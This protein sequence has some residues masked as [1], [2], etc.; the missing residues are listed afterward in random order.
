MPE[1]DP[2][3]RATVLRD[4]FGRVARDLRVSLTD[5][6]NLR[7]SYCMPANGLAWLPTELTLTDAEVIRLCR[8][9]VERL[10]VREIRFT[11]GEPLLRRGLE[12][13]VAA[14]AQLRTDQGQVPGLAL[15]TNALGLEHR[16]Q[17]LA[18]AG[19]QRV[20]VSLDSL[21]PQHFRQ[22]THRDRLADVLA[23]ISAAQA[24][25]LSPLKVNAVIVRGINDTD[26]GRLLDYCLAIGAELRFIEQMPIG[27]PG[28]WDRAQMVTRDDIL[29]LVGAQHEL[30][31]AETEDPS[32]PARI[33]TVD[34]D[35]RQRVGIIASVSE[36]FCD[37]CD[38][39]RLTS[40]G[41]IRSC[42]FAT[43]EVD[44][45]RILRSGDEPRQIEQ[46]IVA[47]WTAA[48]WAKP[49]AHG[50]DGSRFA[51]PSRT[52]SRIGG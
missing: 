16:A 27:P 20:N 48:M 10:G 38:R 21:D 18:A 17:R 23:G 2:A 41:Q 14:V 7:C 15:T 46:R 44:L 33:W 8:I 13:I 36:P 9:G 45:R 28:S 1:P 22:I 3:P 49:E 12:D 52:M 25:G 42:L 34:G 30:T 35:P 50:L 4:R 24:A 32:A 5:R 19:L 40:D 26:A 47:A 6:C 31:P 37:S 51:V 11:G 29:E 43:Q 39:T